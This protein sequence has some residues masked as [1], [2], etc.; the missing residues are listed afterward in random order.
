MHKTGGM[1]CS[2][3]IYRATRRFKGYFI[4]QDLFQ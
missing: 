1:S 3:K 4:A 2:A